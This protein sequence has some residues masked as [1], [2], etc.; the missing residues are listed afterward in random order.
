MRECRDPAARR[1]ADSPCNGSAAA[2][3]WEAAQHAVGRYRCR[4]A[5]IVRSDGHM[6]MG[7]DRPQ[8]R[9]LIRDGRFQIGDVG[10]IGQVDL[11]TS[12][13]CQ[14]PRTRIELDD[15]LHLKLPLVSDFGRE[16]HHSR[17][18]SSHVLI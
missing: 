15:N 8:G 7:H 9:V 4:I 11:D 16:G 17:N 5:G 13:L 14:I 18:D 6:Q 10:L 12:G 1:K 3:G 2:D